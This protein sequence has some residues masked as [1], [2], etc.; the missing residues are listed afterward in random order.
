MNSVMTKPTDFPAFFRAALVRSVRASADEVTALGHAP[1][2]DEM[3]ARAL[4]L[5]SFAFNLPEAWPPARDLLIA[6]APQMERAGHREDWMR[7]L[8]RAIAQSRA[9]DDTAAEGELRLQLGFLYQLLGQ[10]DVAVS[11][12]RASMECFAAAQRLRDQARAMNRLAYVCNLQ[13]NFSEVQT[14]TARALEML[15]PDDPECGASHVAM[16][17]AALD[18]RDW[19]CAEEHFRRSIVYAEQQEDSRLLAKRLNALGIAL[20]RLHG[21][22]EAMDCYQR[23][24]SA[25]EQLGD[26]VEQAVATVNVGVLYVEVAEYVSAIQS[27]EEAKPVLHAVRDTLHL[28]MLYNNQGYAYRLLEEYPLAIRAYQRS[29]AY[30]Q[31]IGDVASLTNTLDGLGVVYTKCAQ[32]DEAV[33]TFRDALAG[34]EQ[35]RH[36]P[37]YEH[38]RTMVQEH[39]DEALDAGG[40]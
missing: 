24:I 21:F 28:A 11:Q 4:H 2:P 37:L 34:L 15:E 25:Y 36:D 30:W 20:I 39:L 38:L 13:R 26:R 3:R 35:I 29:I 33:V 6:L 12:L 5:L 23:A 14:L 18:Q 9:Y 32:L 10:L 1:L 16:G 22:E 31:R 19:R 40:K 17:H 7:Y 8:E 27:Y